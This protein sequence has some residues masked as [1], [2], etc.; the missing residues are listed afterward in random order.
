MNGQDKGR[1]GIGA[2]RAR[3]PH[4]PR[5]V[6]CT[7]CGGGLDLYDEHTQMAVCPYCSSRLAVS[8]AEARVLGK[9][10][11]DW[12]FPIKLGDSFRWD[13]V[14]YEVICRMVTMEE[15]DLIPTYQ[16]LLFN[17]RRPSLWLSEYDRQYDLMGTSHV[18]PDSD[19]FSKNTGS[20]LS[21]HDNREWVCEEKG[22][23]Q[24]VFVDG[25]LPWVARVGDRVQYAAFAEKTGTGEIYEAERIKNE[26]E[27][28]KGRRLSLEEVRRA[29][30]NPRLHE[31]VKDAAR[32]DAAEKRKWYH[33]LMLLAL[34]GLVLNLGLTVFA[35]ISGR[36]IQRYVFN[37][38]QL[39][40]E[41]FSQPFHLS[42]DNTVLKI[43][44]TPSPYLQNAWMA[45][46]VAVVNS[47]D[48]VVHVADKDISY[49]SGYE[50]GEHWS[51]GSHSGS[52][53]VRIPKAGDYR[54]LVHAASAMGNASGATK[55]VHGVAVEVKKGVIPARWF[56]LASVLCLVLFLVVSVKYG[57]WR[58]ESLEDEED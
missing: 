1:F 45:L 50:G 58:S 30:K 8:E 41:A 42:D 34:A 2:G 5:Q 54:L 21:T 11:G 3:P 57:H 32:P 12:E 25:A 4:L 28:G 35:F 20:L 53:L 33:R 18:M 38:A 6:K 27:F 37:A 43:K 9:M 56:I 7:N 55:S 14:R 16:Y 15:D 22:E 51:E 13:G 48:K 19:P 44:A 10:E 49:Y 17:P 36:V 29:F 23:S 46:D 24:M 26:V 31:G 52:M 47:E 40:Q 39:T